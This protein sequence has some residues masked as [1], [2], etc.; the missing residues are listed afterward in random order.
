MSTRPGRRI[1]VGFTALVTLSALVT[2]PLVATAA[3]APVSGHHTGTLADGATWIADVPAGWNGTLLLFSHGFGP[4]TAQ[5]APDPATQSALLAAGYALAGSSYDPNGS[6]WALGSAERDQFQTLAAFKAVV[7]RPARTI[8]VGE[9]MGGLVNAQ[10]VRDAD[11]RIA[12][13]LGL[14]GLVAGGLDLN[15]YQLAGEVVLATLLAPGAGVHLTGYAGSADAAAVA[16]TLTDAVEAAQQTP[17]GRAR[18]A[19][20]AAFLN[21]PT[22]AP[23]QNPPA[24][25]DAVGQETPAGGLDRRRAARLHH[26]LA[27]RDRAGGRR[28]QRLD[29][30]ARLARAARLL[31]PPRRGPGPVSRCRPGSE[32]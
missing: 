4:T 7:A 3:A 23:G 10:M 19:L 14:C 12:G 21:L 9:S 29:R 20:A 22:W 26:R 8:S 32:R 5:D 17:A 25:G 6:W 1:A 11:G 24:P 30:R 16:Q 28:R 15:D 18:I 2:A 13:S 31:R 27:A